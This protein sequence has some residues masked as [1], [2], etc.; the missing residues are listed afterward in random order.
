MLGVHETSR[1]DD[2]SQ[3]SRGSRS[4][5]GPTFP[6]AQCLVDD[7]SSIIIQDLDLNKHVNQVVMQQ[8][9]LHASHQT[10]HA[11]QSF[12]LAPSTG[13]AS[14][15]KKTSTIPFTLAGVMAKTLPPDRH[16][17]P[18][19]LLS[20]DEAGWRSHSSTVRWCQPFPASIDWPL[21]DASGTASGCFSPEKS[22]GRRRH[23]PRDDSQSMISRDADLFYSGRCQAPSTMRWPTS[24]TRSSTTATRE[25]APT[26]GT[27]WTSVGLPHRAHADMENPQR[28]SQPEPY[29]RPHY[30]PAADFDNEESTPTAVSGPQRLPDLAK[31]PAGQ[32]NHVH[33]IERRS[34]SPKSRHLPRASSSA[35]VLPA[36]TTPTWPPCLD[37]GCR[38]LAPPSWRRFHRSGLR[39]VHRAHARGELR[40]TPAAGQR[41]AE[42]AA[43]VLPEEQAR[44]TAHTLRLREQGA[45]KQVEARSL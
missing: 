31:Q 29:E 43:P 39:D 44:L 21:R 4:T 45:P 1:P 25:R 32:D 30:A 10:S 12:S 37:H 42:D 2:P 8:P 3:A 40:A 33:R 34:L 18:G 6:P 35:L 9:Q 20:V 41:A 27:S 11:A 24:S 7:R 26:P 16:P 22:V 19:R 23:Q 15:V 5:P 36:A 17:E 38:A 28:L 13:P 14:R